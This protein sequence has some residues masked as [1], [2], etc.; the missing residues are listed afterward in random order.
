MKL[1]HTVKKDLTD[2]EFDILSRNIQNAIMDIDPDISDVYEVHIDMISG[3]WHIEFV[4]KSGR[5]PVIKVDAYTVYD[6]K[7]NEVL[8]VSPTDAIKFTENQHFD[9]YEDAVEFS[10]K[11]HI[12]LDFLVE[13]Y[14]FEYTL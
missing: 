8:K 6:D 14:E 11:L 5:T 1:L 3:D 7:D 4:P 9:D 2:K 13:L 12:I 10:S